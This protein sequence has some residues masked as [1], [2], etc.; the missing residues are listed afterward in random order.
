MIS[1]DSPKQ[2]EVSV[3]SVKAHPT[4]PEGPRLADVF[5]FDKPRDALEGIGSGFGNAMKG[6]FGGVA[7]M[8]AAPIQGAIEGSKDGT[9]EAVK[10]ASIGLGMGLIGGAATAIYGVGSGIAQV[11]RGIMNTPAATAATLEVCILEW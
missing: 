3:E 5:N 4:K 1:T 7:M 10:G 11:G 6:V 2:G 8:V 9:M